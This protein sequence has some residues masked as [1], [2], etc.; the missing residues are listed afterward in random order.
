MLHSYSF[1][2]FRSFREKVEV[3]F[4]LTEKDAVHGW[5]YESPIS[6]QRL[7]TAVAV[8]GPNAS[9]KTSLVQPLAFL[10]WFVRGSFHSKPDSG[11][12][13]APHFSAPASATEFEVIVDSP[14]PETLLRY[15]LSATQRAVLSESL[16]RKLR[17]GQ[18]SVIFDRRRAEDGSQHVFQEGFGLDQS[19]AENVR[20]DVSL[21]SWAAQFDVPFAKT[22][23]TFAFTT[24][25]FIG[26][27]WWQPQDHTV[28]QCV[29]HYA[30]NPDLQ[31]RLPEILRRWDLGLAD[32]EVQEIELATA[33]EPQKHWIAFGVHRE[34][35][36]LKHRLPF[37]H[38]SS[39][40]KAA[41]ALLTQFLP[42]LEHG[43]L[44]AWDELDS[45]LHPHLLEAVLDLFASRKT[46]PHGAQ[47]IFT[48]HSV[49]VMKWLQKSQI[50]L[51]DK[52]GLDSHAWRL[53]SMEGVRSDENRAAKYLAGAYGA[54][55]R[56]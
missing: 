2:N 26:G 4:R 10:N 27:R 24:N 11:V 3:S 36:N 51:V 25:M 23:T 53:D 44:I 14:E 15:R 50:V 8:L 13:V 43:G 19:R 20:P 28:D 35:E 55:P 5:D 33:A 18:W 9:G 34:H 22:L 6:N 29:Q 56:L 47:I 40:T 37:L 16:E 32:L 48:C 17:R 7:S 38:E 46:N 42:V 49:E 21:I 31:R 52:D 12:P 54:V 45:D 41:F 39:G 1:S 30:Q